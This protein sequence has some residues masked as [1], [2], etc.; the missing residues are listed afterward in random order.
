[1]PTRD[2][3]VIGG[4]AGALAS[5]RKILRGLPAD[6]PA[7]LF[8]VIHIAPDSPSVLANV[9]S[10]AGPLPAQ[11][12]R[13]GE[14]IMPRRVYVAPPDHHLLLNRGRVQVSRGPRENRFRPAVDP[15]FRTAAATYGARVIGII[16]SGGQDDGVLGLAQI[17]RRG[18]IAI[19][20][21]PAEAE[22]SGMP[23]SAIRQVDVDHVLRADDMSAVIGGL[24]RLPDEAS[25][26]TRNQPMPINLS[27]NGHDAA[28][29]GTDALRSGM[30]PGPPSP[31]R[32]PECG[33]ALWELQDGEL[34]RFQCHVGHGF[35]GESLVAAQSDEL[36]GAL[37]TA[38]RALKE[39]AALRRRMAAH[40]RARGM[41]AIAEAYEEQAQES[42]VRAQV[43]RGT[44]VGDP[45]RARA[46]VPSATEG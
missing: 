3:I 7:A 21:D 29:A 42:E 39:S 33:G 36:E 12:A 37:W 41:A 28:E 46:T 1:M 14:P 35:N 9:L 5:L 24:V 34:V 27:E 32:C 26:M 23:E 38:L 4:S 30:L 15:L 16:L 11:A 2:I 20:Q 43:I 8:V 31:F 44:L 45:I 25:V 10:R 17:K 13:D 18:G 6:F 40:A 19:V 22:A